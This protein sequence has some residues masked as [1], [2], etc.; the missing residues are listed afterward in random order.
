MV[1][2]AWICAFVLRILIL[3][4]LGANRP[5]A[6]SE[7][8]TA[9]LRES[10][11][12][13]AVSA[14]PLT[15]IC[16]TVFYLSGFYT[17]GRVY[18]GRFKALIIFQAVSLAFLLFWSA[19]T[20]LRMDPPLPRAIVIAGWL[21]TLLLIE[22][23]RLVALIWVAAV[24]VEDRTLRY[25]GPRTERVLVIGGAGYLGSVLVRKLVAK[26]YFVRVFDALLY[27][28]RAM[29]ELRGHPRFDFTQG[30]F[31]D[32]EA[33]VGATRDM[34]VVVHLGA[35]VGDPASELDQEL[36]REVNV[37]ATRLIGEVARGF[38]TRRLI[39][40]STCSVYG[41][42]D[43]TLDERSAPN[44]QTVYDRTKLQAEQVLLSMAGGTFAPVILRLG[45]LYGLSYRP[46]F[47]LVV[48]LLIAKAVTER[49]ITIFG[50]EQWRP[51]V[52]VDDAAD[53]IMLCLEAPIDIVGGEIFNVGS[54]TQNFRIREIARFIQ[55]LL[56]DTAVETNDQASD[57]KNYL[58]SCDK[59]LRVLGFRPRK[60]IK[61]A[62]LE[63]SEAF[64]RGWISDYQAKEYSNYQFLQ[65]DFEH[66][67]TKLGGIPINPPPE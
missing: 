3:L 67:L 34:D 28:H 60:T 15:A 32:V 58:V 50:G 41:S 2:L 12:A 29:A 37:A 56:P 52:H 11:G 49:R 21:L 63:I 66:R 18:R 64:H 44:P 35:I 17:Y 65:E 14:I 25:R 27:G 40:T 19:W 54:T 9:L 7:A 46:R 13:Y 16:L 22:F 39:F 43:E 5:P 23:S 1:N 59:I 62:V 51:F 10:G 47:D 36:T 26:G 24:R 31:R 38:G 55:E 61:D 8:Y 53:A 33:V 30:D 42:S 57:V 20:F 45:T 4:W 6:T 48:N